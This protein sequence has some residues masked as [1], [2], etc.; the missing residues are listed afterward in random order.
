VPPRAWKWLLRDILQSA[1]R[2]QRYTRELTLAQFAADE[3]RVDGV[4]RNFITIGEAATHLPVEVQSRIPEIPWKDL[5][6]MRN[7]IVYAYFAIDL[8]VVWHTAQ[9]DI[10]R[11][12]AALEAVMAADYEF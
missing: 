1:E 3:L 6:G 4:V 7:I 9:N 11:L 5:R 12:I 2:I 10:P 8:E